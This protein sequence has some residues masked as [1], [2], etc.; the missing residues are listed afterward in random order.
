MFSDFWAS[1]GSP[2]SRSRSTAARTTSDSP[3]GAFPAGG[4]FAGAEASKTPEQETLYGGAAGEQLD[5]C[6]HA[7][8]D[9]LSSILEAPPPDALMDP[10]NAAKLQGG[11]E[12]MRQFLPAMT[13]SVWH[14]A[15]G[16]NP[17][18]PRPTTSKGKRALEKTMR[19][20]TAQFDYRG[21]RLVR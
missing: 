1:Q 3:S 12:S 6:Y 9:R 4:I 11:G 21:H 19:D 2:R 10:A 5:P 14:F 18:P 7:A 13:H 20:R 8:C 16:K 17:M 15:K